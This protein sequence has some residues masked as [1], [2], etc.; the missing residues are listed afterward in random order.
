MLRGLSNFLGRASQGLRCL[1]DGPLARRIGCRHC[2]ILC[3]GSRSLPCRSHSLDFPARYHLFPSI[4]GRGAV[5]RC[6]VVVRVTI[7][8]DISRYRGFPLSDQDIHRHGDRHLGCRRLRARRQGHMHCRNADTITAQ[9]AETR[10]EGR[11]KERRPA[12]VRRRRLLTAGSI[13]PSA[14]RRLRH[15]PAPSWGA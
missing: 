13:C 5:G 10:L 1:R 14:M 9:H 15:S 2:S 6:D 3:T 11:P 4:G 7:E 12:L 8:G